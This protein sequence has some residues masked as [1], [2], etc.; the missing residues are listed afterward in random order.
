[1]GLS[2]REVDWKHIICKDFSEHSNPSFELLVEGLKVVLVEFETADELKFRDSKSSVVESSVFLVNS[3]SW[4]E[5]HEEWD[6]E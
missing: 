2:E 3:A 1:M 6:Q 5:W 4:S